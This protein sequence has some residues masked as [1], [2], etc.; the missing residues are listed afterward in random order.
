MALLVSALFGTVSM[1]ASSGTVAKIGSTNYSSL[2]AA[3]KAAKSG[4]TIVLQKDVSYSSV[5]SFSRSGK[6]V[7]LNLNKHTIT[8]KKST[9]YLYVKKGTLTIKNGTIKQTGTTYSEKEDAVSGPVIKTAEAATVNITSGTYKGTLQNLGTMTISGGSFYNACTSKTVSGFGSKVY[10]TLLANSGTMT[11][12]GGKFTKKALSYGC[13][14]LAYNDGTMTI[15]SGDFTS[16]G[17]GISNSGKLTIKNGTFTADCDKTA[18]GFGI[19]SDNGG[20]VVIKDGT[21]TASNSYATIATWVGKVTISGGT[22]INDENACLCTMGGTVSIK[23]G[24]FKAGGN[25]IEACGHGVDGGT[26]YGK[27]TISK[28]TFKTTGTKTIILYAYDY[29]KI[30]VTGGT[31]TGKKAYKYAQ[32]K[33]ST[34]AK[35]GVVKISGGTFTTKYGEY[36]A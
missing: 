5:L 23:G 4:Q 14:S 9:A 17:Y 29:G 20:T 18:S 22:F 12:S 8:F 35:K 24:T 13:G 27:V 10:G 36:T 2:A 7:T 3:F 32:L 31:F 30:T 25:V 26:S 6:S 1:A 15:S 34:G 16:T 11:I 21:F 19:I 33:N 28:G